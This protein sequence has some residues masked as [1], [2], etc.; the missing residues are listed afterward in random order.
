MPRYTID[1]GEK[2]DKLLTDLAQ[3]KEI[4]KSELVRRAVASYAYFDEERTAGNRISVVD[5]KNKTVK[6]VV[7]P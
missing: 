2:F 3:S 1:L 4:T 6:E 5:D 7:L